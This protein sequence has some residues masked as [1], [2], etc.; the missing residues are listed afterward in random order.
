MFSYSLQHSSTEA[1]FPEITICPDYNGHIFD[2]DVLCKKYG[3]CDINNF[4]YGFQIPNSTYES[5]LLWFDYFKNISYELDTLISA[6]DI[7]T[8]NINHENNST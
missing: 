6:Y 7:T 5:E 8:T 3:L 2:W 1:T 4:K